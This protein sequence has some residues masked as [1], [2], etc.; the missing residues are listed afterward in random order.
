MVEGG[1]IDR[2]A[3]SNSAADV[4]SD[5]V[6]LDEAIAVAQAYAST[7]DDTLIIVVA[8]HET[9]GMD[10]SLTSSG[11]PDEDGPFYM[12]GGT[13]FF[14]NWTTDYHTG[15]DVPTVA[16]GPWS[17][18]LVGVYENTHIHD[19]MRLALEGPLDI[20]LTQVA[21]PPGGSLVAP[22]DNITYTLVLT[23]GD[24]TGAVDLRLIDTLP[25]DAD[26]V[27]GSVKATPGWEVVAV[28]PP[29]LVVTGTLLPGGVVTS[30][31]GVTVSD[32]ASGTLLVNMAQVIAD[33]VVIATSSTT[34]QVVAVPE[35][36]IVK[37]AEP[38]IGS[39]VASGDRITYTVSVLNS[40]GPEDD[41]IVSDGIDVAHVTLVVSRTT[42]GVLSGPNPIRVTD[43]G[44]EPG[45]RVT[46]TLG[47]DVIDDVSGNM[48]S[49][50]ASLVSSRT[51]PQSSNLVIHFLAGTDWRSVRL[52]LLLREYGL[53]VPAAGRQ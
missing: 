39:I 19:V 48:I 41:V 28:P 22:G 25:T 14:V 35:L 29:A 17:D 34:H 51:R 9:G 15:V 23:H 11:A 6:G 37:A 21:A 1:Q 40:G 32:V 16:R 20:S 46:L 2:A 26:Y 36:S 7:A 42:E 49:N 47:V 3:H 30:T 53:P 24:A 5:T 10:V 44:L 4:I 33:D 52:P 38:V 45:Q 12:P 31:F 50:T 8:D 27:S 13:P 43:F 18:L